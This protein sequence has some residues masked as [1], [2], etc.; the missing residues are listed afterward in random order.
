[1]E[2]LYENGLIRNVADIYYLQKE[3]LLGLERMAEKSAQNLLDG[4]EDSKKIPFER[5]LFALAIRHVGVTVAKKLAHYFKNIDALKNASELQLTEVGE[6]GEIIAR[7]VVEYFS[8]EKHLQLIERLK[9]A[10][11]RF[12]LGEEEMKNVSD[13]LKGFS[14]VVSGVFERFSRDEIKNTIVKNGGKC[15]GSVSGKTDF[16]VAGEGMGPEKMKKAEKLGIKIINE[17][18]FLKM[19]E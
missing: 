18:E 12:E 11:L 8:R 4:I 16:L 6:I 9:N 13:K 19:I 14:F 10:G 3:Q 2:L 15:V 5:V 17:S 7:S 1:V